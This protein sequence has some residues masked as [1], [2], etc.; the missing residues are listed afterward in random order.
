V[1]TTGYEGTHTWSARVNTND[2]VTDSFELT[3]DAFIEVPVFVNPK[4]VYLQTDGAKEATRGVEITAGLDKPLSIEPAEFDLEN[5]VAYSIHEIEKGRKYRII[6]TTLPGTQRAP[7]GV[8]KLKTNYSEK[9]ELAI[10]IRVSR[11]GGRP[12]V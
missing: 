11:T 5:Q 12:P 2:P 8:L 3:V 9:P 6:F 4:Y 10:K 7:S 1:D